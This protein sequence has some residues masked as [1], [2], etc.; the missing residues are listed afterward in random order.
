MLTQAEGGGYSV[1]VA[2][3][4][5]ACVA[6]NNAVAPLE[7]MSSD[8]MSQAAKDA[9]DSI[10]PAQAIS[11]LAGAKAALDAFFAGKQV[12]NITWRVKNV[13]GVVQ[14]TCT[15]YDDADQ[16]MFNRIMQ[17]QSQVL[18]PSTKY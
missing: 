11:R 10:G 9:L 13:V 17:S 4:M 8:T 7:A 18:D 2:A 12:E 3:V 5:S 15:I 16:A 6:T 1:D 14:E